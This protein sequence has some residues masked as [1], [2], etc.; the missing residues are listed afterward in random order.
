[1]IIPHDVSKSREN[2]IIRTLLKVQFVNV[3][4]MK[5]KKYFVSPE[6]SRNWSH[7]VLTPSRWYRCTRFIMRST[8]IYEFNS[9]TLCDKF[10]DDFWKEIISS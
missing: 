6:H 5:I 7:V 8:N 4:Y 2:D 10:I 1:M 9:F 3:K